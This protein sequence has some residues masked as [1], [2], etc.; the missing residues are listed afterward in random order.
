MLRNYLKIAWRNLL[1]NRSFSLINILGLAV[2][3]SVCLLIIMI[4]VDQY[5][6]DSYHS[7]GDRVYRIHTTEYQQNIGEVASSALPLAEKLKNDYPIIE[8]AAVLNREIGG[9][10]IYEDKF[11]TGGGYF[12][13]GNIFKILDFSFKEG[14]PETSLNEPFS[15]VI[16]SEMA[17]ILFN[18]ESALGKTVA[19]HDKDVQPTGLEEGNFETDFGYFT[20][21]GVLNPNPGKTHLPFKILA[22]MSTRKSLPIEALRSEKENDWENVWTNYTYVL[23]KK[24][25]RKENLQLILDEVSESIYAQKYENKHSF[26]AMALGEITP[27]EMIGNTTHVSVPKIVL[28]ILGILCLIVMFSACLNYT[29]MSVARALTRVKEVG[30]R[31]VSGANRRQVFAQ[32]ITEAVVISLCSLVFA[33]IFLQFL[34]KGFEGLTFNQYLQISFRQSLPAMLLFLGFSLVVG[35]VAGLLP[36][37]YV[38]KLN[39]IN[40]FNKLSGVKLFKSMGI[41]NVLMVLQFTI[42]LIFII[43]VVLIQ[44]QAKHILNFDFGFNKDNVVTVKLFNTENYQRFAQAISSNPSVSAVGASSLIP[45]AG[46]NFGTEV[47][48]PQNPLDSIQTNYFDINSGTVSVLDLELIAGNNLPEGGSENLVLINELA[49]NKFDLGSP[50]DAIGKQLVIMD[51]EEFKNVEVA[52]IVKNFQFLSPDQAM[53]SLVLRSRNSTMGFALVRVNGDNPSATIASLESAWKEVNPTTKF[54]YKYLDQ[55]L[56]F[57]HEVLG[58]VISVIGLISFLAIFV[59]CLGLLGM[60]TYT[61]QT[62]VKEIGI[63]KT[64]GSSIPEIIALLS[65]GFI[66]LLFIAVLIAVP[67]AYFINNFWLEFFASRV[68]I[69]VVPIGIGV[70]SLMLISF[71]I[72]FSQAYRAAIINPIESLKNQ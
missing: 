7:K 6:F 26:K 51:G 58:D 38:A 9:D 24:G 54:S 64:L 35:V 69:G 13:D 45:A 23:L 30:I 72:I 71:G 65:K 63:R 52:G 67:A 1:R 44:S 3:M 55:E 40:L 66:G 2:S 5:S 31:K 28:M 43:S 41:R 25:Q 21:T 70:G 57:I 36:A 46:W 10:L 18:G 62:R 17:D 60:A 22:S 29:N 20:I 16:T 15:L 49:V 27:M 39:P 37:T 48:N 53:E 47:V 59:S 4:G 34:Q 12:A 11:A 42:S 61:A 14:N 56:L 33:F 68:S 50:A 8:E 19:F 32:F